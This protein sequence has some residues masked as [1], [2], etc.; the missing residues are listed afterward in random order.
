MKEIIKKPVVTEKYVPLQEQGVFVFEVNL[1]ANKVEIKKEVEKMYSV[2]VDSVR[3]LIKPR[4]AKTR[5][6]KQGVIS[7]KT[8]LVKRAIVKLAEGETI[9]YYSEMI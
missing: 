8:P 1:K 6:T 3:T 5:F 9:D 4:K 2:S 7:G